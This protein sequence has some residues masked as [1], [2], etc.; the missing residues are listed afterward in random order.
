MKEEVL[1]YRK[2]TWPDRQNKIKKGQVVKELLNLEQR[3]F[4]L[5]LYAE[6]LTAGEVVREIK[7][8]YDIDYAEASLKST[9]KS[10]K[11][12]ATIERFREE[13]MS[14]V[15]SVPIANKR[16]RIDDLEGVRNKILKCI[17]DNPLKTKSDKAEFL[18]MTRRLNETLCVGRE[19]MEAKPFM[20][21][22]LS[23]G[24]F[25]SMSDKEIQE[26]KEVLIAKATGTYE[27][28]SNRAGNVD[29][30]EEFSDIEESS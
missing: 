9:V 27:G 11:W 18:M 3:T 12:Q 14:K 8:T 5:R 17:K 29:E 13:Y 25:S 28:R 21:Q 4:A 7:S 24:A 10:K 23:I 30:G 2:K 6:G 26:R 15:K 16:V 1:D 19:E 22:Q 20:V